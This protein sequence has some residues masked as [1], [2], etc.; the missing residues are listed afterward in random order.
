LFDTISAP[1]ILAKE[2]AEADRRINEQY[3][4]HPYLSSKTYNGVPCDMFD[5]YR[6]MGMLDEVA[7]G[8]WD[9][10]VLVHLMEN[11]R[12]MKEC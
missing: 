2:V 11:Q 8:S 6:Q 10:T 1:K 5:A 12:T 4:S 7:P 9:E 3:R